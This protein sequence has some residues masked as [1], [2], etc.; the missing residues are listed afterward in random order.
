MKTQLLGVPEQTIQQYSVVSHE[1]AR[2]MA[3]RLRERTH[4]TI[5]ISLTGVAGP[6]RLADQSPG[7]VYIGIAFKDQPVISKVYHFPAP[8]R[9]A[10][11]NR[12]VNEVMR[13]LYNLIK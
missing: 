3:E 4:S 8:N 7:T 13:L 9:N 12:S 6:N 11:R 5:A 2:S 10:V 1:V